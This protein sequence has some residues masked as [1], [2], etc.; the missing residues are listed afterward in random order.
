MNCCEKKSVVKGTGISFMKIR[1]ERG[2]DLK[3]SILKT[4]YLDNE[5]IPLKIC[6]TRAR[7][8]AWQVHLRLG[9]IGLSNFGMFFSS[10]MFGRTG[11][12]G[13]DRTTWKLSHLQIFW[14]APAM[15][16]TIKE[17]KEELLQAKKSNL[18]GE[19]KL[20]MLWKHKFAK[21]DSPTNFTQSSKSYV[22]WVGR[23]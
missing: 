22:V 5:I 12:G 1:S 11:R 2:A 23:L 6:A 9:G 20:L 10:T 14:I 18:L 15:K 7:N 8:S 19:K 3:R 13:A 4:V 17:R 21:C 16:E